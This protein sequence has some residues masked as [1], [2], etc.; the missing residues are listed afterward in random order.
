MPAVF[1]VIQND[2]KKHHKPESENA[3]R[4]KTNINC[5]NCLAK[6]SPHLNSAQ[7]IGR[8]NV[9]TSNSDKILTVNGDGITELE[10]V[11]IVQNAGYKIEKFIPETK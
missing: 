10:V 9:D 1:S 11:E 2:Q 8:W 3:F 4:F 5:G 6:V 7:G